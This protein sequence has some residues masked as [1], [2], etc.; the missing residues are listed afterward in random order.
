M[1]LSL[2][3]K[4]ICKQD[5]FFS[6]GTIFPMLSM[7]TIG[8][9]SLKIFHGIISSI[10][11]NMMNTKKIYVFLSAFFTANFSQS[12]YSRTKSIWNV[13]DLSFHSA[14]KKSGTRSGTKNFCFAMDFTSSFD[15]STAKFT[16]MSL[17]A[18]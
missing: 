6:A 4:S 11:I 15:N 9:K 17:Y 16:R 14:V 12:F 1:P 8:A 3:R 13:R 7:M 18:C 10:F 5:M 2:F